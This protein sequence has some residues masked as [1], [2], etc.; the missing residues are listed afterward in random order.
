MTSH[1]LVHSIISNSG[2]IKKNGGSSSLENYVLKLDENGK[3]DASFL[4]TIAIN[5]E[6]VPFGRTGVT[7]DQ[8]LKVG[9]VYSNLTGIRL[10]DDGTLI[11]VSAQNSAANT[12]DIEVRINGSLSSIA[13]VSVVAALGNHDSSFAYPLFA[14]DYVAVY[15]S[16]TAEDPVVLLRFEAV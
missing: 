4:P 16:G 3:L 10:P 15:C 8:Y 1:S 12:F 7:T 2:A 5:R 6:Y 11:A 9:E 14:G 13:T